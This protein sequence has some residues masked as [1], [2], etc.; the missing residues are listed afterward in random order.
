MYASPMR[1]R[2]SRL[3]YKVL[4]ALPWP[5]KMAGANIGSMGDGAP[6]WGANNLRTSSFS[7]WYLEI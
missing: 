2:G 1:P 7:S 3:N 5:A 4:K 6:L